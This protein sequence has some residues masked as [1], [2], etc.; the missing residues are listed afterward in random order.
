[1]ERLP[2]GVFGVNYDIGNSASLGFNPK[3]EI[4]A[5]GPRILNVHVKDRRMGGTTVPL[6]TGNADFPTVFRALRRAGYRG[7][8]ILQTARA[9]DG[10]HAGALR[11]YREM[12][13]RWL[14][15]AVHAA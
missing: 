1:M 2:L 5:Y 4:Q 11:R 13:R 10:D 3:E 14:A 6:G 7:D 12:T 15:E 8:F 9:E